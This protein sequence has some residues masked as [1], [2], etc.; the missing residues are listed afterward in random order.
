MRFNVRRAASGL[1]FEQLVEA[2][3]VSRQTLLRLSAG[4]ARGEVVTWMRLSIAFQVSIDELLGP[5]FIDDAPS[6]VGRDGT[7]VSDVG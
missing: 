3:G 4:Q 2:S 1:T 5:V 7:G 6:V